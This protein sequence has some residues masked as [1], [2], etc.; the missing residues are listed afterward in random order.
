MDNIVMHFSCRADL[1]LSSVA[2]AVYHYTARLGEAG[3]YNGQFKVLW[4]KIWCHQEIIS[5]SPV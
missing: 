1:S 4:W 3:E 5:A 2:L